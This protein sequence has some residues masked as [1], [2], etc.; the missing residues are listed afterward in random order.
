MRHDDRT[1]TGSVVTAE[2]GLVVRRDPRR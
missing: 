2:H 1:L